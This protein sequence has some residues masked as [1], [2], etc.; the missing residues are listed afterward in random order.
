MRTWFS[1]FSSLFHR[2]SLE[3]RLDE[4]VR[5]HLDMEAA[6]QHRRGLT[7]EEAAFAARR[8]FGGEQ[9]TREEYRDQRGLPMLETLL[10][11]LQYGLRTLARNPGFTLVA[12]LSLALGIGANTAIF[13]LIN[14]V[15]LRS[16]PV[17]A[18]GELVA[19]GNIGRPGG[20]STGGARL[21]VFSYP[22]YQRLRDQNQVFTGLFASGRTGR[23]DANIEGGGDE[24]IRGRLVSD[25]YFTVLGVEP[26]RGRLFTTGD[27]SRQGANPSI[28]ISFDYWQHRFAADPSILGKAIKING[29]AFTI[30]GVGPQGFSGEVV[31]NLADVWI[32]LSMQAQVNPGDGR[33]D[34]RD[35]NWLLLLGRL[36]PGVTFEHARAEITAL[37][38]QG[39]LDFEGAAS[40]DRAREIRAQTVDIQLG[41]RGFSG[42]RNRFRQPLLTLMFVVGL[43]LLIAC[44]NVANLLLARATTRQKEI[45]VRL[46]VGA[47]RMRLV[48]QLLTESV[49]LASIGGVGGLLLAWA[50]SGVLLQLASNRPTP[51]PLDVKPDS[52]MLIFTAAVS[53]LTGVLFGL[54]PALRSTRVDLAPALKESARSVTGS[55]GWQLGKFLVVGQVALSLLLLV[56]AGLF[57]RSLI[58]LETLDVGYPRSNLVTVNVDPIASGY[59]VS[60]D[61]PMTRQLIER[62]QAVPGVLGATVSMNGIFG[63]TDSTSDPLTVEGFTSTR[64]EDVTAN[65]DCAGPHY[66]QVVGVPLLNGRD[67]DER[68]KTGA[69]PVAILNQTMARFYFGSQDPVGRTIRAGK[70]AQYTIVGVSRDMKEKELKAKTERRFYVPFFQSKER[71]PDV[72]FEIRTRGDA[73]LM[74]APIRAEVQAFDPHLKILNLESVRTLIDQSIVDERLIAQLSGFFG[75][76]ALLLAATGLYGIMAYTISRRANEIGLRMALGADKATMIRMVLRETLTLVTAG[77]AIGIPVA[78][79]ASR[80]ISASLSGLSANDPLTLLSAVVVMLGAAALAAWIPARRAAGIDP[81]IALRQE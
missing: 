79:A 76:L 34:K 2:R 54:V 55:G 63:G 78:L 33:L 36:K 29:T 58:N 60:Q 61:V 30:I 45:S 51:I 39:L 11:D 13:T 73:S 48:R 72:V 56:G 23:L 40:A 12:A 46:A 27:D 20:I 65:F 70:E 74:L 75:A 71:L 6:Q 14:A 44:A 9:N 57:V 7:E 10:K 28:V 8:A 80:L 37:A 68:D 24:P 53:L 52:V 21:D 22:L 41:G 15:M 17:K 1:K 66:F 50:G 81:L 16:L 62:F 35:S 26:L 69:P 25:N 4:E 38:I 43:V 59:A 32:P 67:F 77:I 19:I 5:F 64:R 47:S 3:E 49:L 31:G 18:P 42:L